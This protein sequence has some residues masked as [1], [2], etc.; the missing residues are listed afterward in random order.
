[1]RFKIIFQ[2]D[3]KYGDCLPVNYQYEQSAMIYK[4]LSKANAEFSA[5]LHDNG[6]K[7]DNGKHFKL[8]CYSR[9]QFEKYRI[10]PKAGCIN[11][12]GNKIE[13]LVS[14]L[15]EQTTAEFVQGLFANQ[16]VVV[17]N[18]DYRVALDVVGIEAQPSLSL[19][20]K[21]EFRAN[22]AICIRERQGDR[23]Q[24]L[25]PMDNH[26]RDGLLKGLLAR[27]ESFYGQSF[28][29][30]VSSFDFELM[31]DKP[32]STLVTIKA[33]T[34]DQT[35]VRGFRY[36]FRLTAPIELMKIAYDGGL[37]ELCS[38]GFGFIEIK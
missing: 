17:G 22:S 29:G 27:Y 37:G 24:Y 31:T 8:F 18:K 19:E 30:D 34:P 32:K 11:I 23:V 16:H 28:T 14:F 15:P 12:I 35:R 25:S 20:E 6:F 38:Q 3:R 2:I 21:M 1:M 9:F 26:Y 5:W 10:L 33:G 36:D 4:I 7:L 13:W